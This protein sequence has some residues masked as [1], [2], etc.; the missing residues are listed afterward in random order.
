MSHR[1]LGVESG[2]RETRQEAPV[3]TQMRDD[4]GLGCSLI[5]KIVSMDYIFKVRLTEF[6]CGL[7][8]GC[9]RK[10]NQTRLC[11][12]FSEQHGQ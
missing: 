7:A 5:V 6:A 11:S 9:E 1:L 10:K 12:L 2:N 3:I 4:D 8:M